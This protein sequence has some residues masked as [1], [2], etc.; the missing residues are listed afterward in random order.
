M[1]LERLQ[2]VGADLG[3]HL[4]DHLLFYHD[5]V[6][7]FSGL[8]H[9]STE[10][11]K[12]GTHIRRFRLNGQRI[13]GQ[14]IC[15][16]FVDILLETCG[17]GH[18]QRDANNTDRAGEGGQQRS[19]LFRSQV[20]KAKGH[21]CPERHGGFAHIL[22]FRYCKA[23]F[24]HQVWIGVV[25]D[26]TIFHP[27]NSVCVVFRQFRIV[28]HHHHQSVPG[29]FLQQFHDLNTGFRIQCAGGFVSQQDIRVIDQGSGDGHTL[30]LATGH[31]IGLFVKLI[32][33]AHILQSLG[34]SSAAFRTGNTGNSQ[35]QFHVSQNRLVGNQ[36][37]TLENETDGMVAVRIPVP[38]CIFLGRNTVDDQITAVIPVQT[39]NDIQ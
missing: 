3:K 10:C 35:R 28:G 32:A 13:I 18:D 37:V 34:C 9:R 33:Q 23:L 17:Q 14:G 26:L 30:H 12:H 2:V 31:L 22:V 25:N 36:I 7:R 19:C 5:S 21:C 38:I 24:I 1:G 11:R 20:I 27:D 29:D 4:S 15:L 8:G 39:A 6:I 16:N